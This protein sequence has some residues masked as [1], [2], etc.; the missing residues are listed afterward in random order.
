MQKQKKILF[1]H[2]FYASGQCVPA[3]ALKEAYEG[4]A[5]VLTP[6]LPLQPVDAVRLIRD[7]CD[8]EK[9][10]ILVGNSCGSF[11]AQMISPIIGVFEPM[12]LAHY[13]HSFHFPGGHTPTAD[14]F[15]T[16]YVPL[17]EKLLL[18][19]DWEE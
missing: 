7:I 9:P 2:G 1:L 8:Q 16:W 13:T 15:K 19:T 18:E 12:F 10:D 3:L 5:I 4:K 14:H 17:I 6:D 11:Y